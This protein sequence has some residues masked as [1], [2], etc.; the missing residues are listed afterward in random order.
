MNL[1]LLHLCDSLFPIGAFGYSDGLEAAT[2]VRLKADA[3][4]NT[5]SATHFLGDWIDAVLD[6]SIGRLEGPAIWHA[7]IAVVERAWS[8]LAAL[9]EELTAIRPAS[10]TR[11]ASHAMGHRLLIA[12]SVLHADERLTRVPSP[13]SLPV[14]FAAACACSGVDRRESVE[15]YAYTRLAATVSA[16]MRVLPLGQTEAHATLARAL[17]RVPGI[18]DAI[19][20]RDARIESFSPALDIAAM[21]QQYLPSRLFR[22]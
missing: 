11:S 5:A 13:C 8:A 6:E 21:T 17:E 7:W 22:S 3:T 10:A 1:S 12:W 16:A 15:A 18:A 20:T 14:A 4:K 19:A 9:D 2:T